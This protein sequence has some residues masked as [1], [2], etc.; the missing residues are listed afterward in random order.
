MNINPDSLIKL[1]RF[2]SVVENIY[3]ALKKRAQSTT[4]V[5]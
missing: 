3:I 2:N 5:T 4:I 1:G